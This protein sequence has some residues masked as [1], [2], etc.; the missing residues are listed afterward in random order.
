[1][2]AS[3]ILFP[4]LAALVVV[5]IPCLAQVPSHATVTFASGSGAAC[6]G[7]PAPG[8]NALSVTEKISEPAPA[9]NGGSGNPPKASQPTF[10]DIVLTKNVDDCSVPL[11]TLLFPHQVVKSVVISLFAFTT[12]VM[13]ITVTDAVITSMSDAESMGAAPSERLTLS[14]AKITILDPVTNKSSCWDRTTNTH[15]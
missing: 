14:Y 2:N 11:Y 13:R 10:E 9:T 5:A 6:N 12:E 3:R 1:M 4:L 7:F 15:C 8:F